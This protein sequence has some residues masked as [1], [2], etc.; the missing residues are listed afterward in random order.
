[1]KEDKD[2]IMT[3]ADLHKKIESYGSITMI[4]RGLKSQTFELK[5]SMRICLMR[6]SQ[7]YS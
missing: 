7:K 5:P 1:M 6:I 2:P 3:F 4:Y